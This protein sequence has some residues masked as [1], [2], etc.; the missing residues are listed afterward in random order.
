MSHYSAEGIPPNKPNIVS[1]QGPRTLG[2]GGYV[3]NQ[4]RIRLNFFKSFNILYLGRVSCLYSI[5]KDWMHILAIDA[6]KHNRA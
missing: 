2:V 3:F 4:V 5:L 6:S 1:L